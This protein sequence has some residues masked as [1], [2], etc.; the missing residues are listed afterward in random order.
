M[1]LALV[2]LF[3]TRKSCLSHVRGLPCLERRY[4]R[5]RGSYRKSSICQAL[6]EFQAMGM[7]GGIWFPWLSYSHYAGPAPNQSLISPGHPAG[8]R[9][10]AMTLS[11]CSFTPEDIF[12]PFTLYSSPLARFQTS[13][14]GFQTQPVILLVSRQPSHADRC[15][16]FHLP[17]AVPFS[18]LALRCL[19][20]TA[21]FM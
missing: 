21:V 2:F 5:G 14:F 19:P 11:P 8:L 6:G 12:C 9:L 16:P 18:H 7:G 17:I 4:S 13:G 10:S 1:L 20:P 3:I 15:V